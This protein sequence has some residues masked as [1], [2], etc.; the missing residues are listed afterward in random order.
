MITQYTWH[1]TEVSEALKSFCDKKLERLNTFSDDITQIHVTFTIT[2]LQHKA[3]ANIAVKG[4]S[5]HASSE[6]H[7]FFA[8]VDVLIDKLARQLKKHKEKQSVHR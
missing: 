6:A 5:I 4:P 1:N 8:A 3:E 2:H 7:D